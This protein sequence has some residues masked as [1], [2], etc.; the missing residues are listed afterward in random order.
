MRLKKSSPKTPSLIHIKLEYPE[1]KQSKKDM[2][3]SELNLLKIIEGITKYKKLRLEELEKKEKISKKFKDT[4]SNITKLQ[5]IFPKLKI[6]KILEKKAPITQEIEIK[7]PSRYVPQ[8]KS[9]IE[10]QL[11]QIQEKL[12]SLE[13]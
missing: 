11:S 7:A 8:K 9:D 5:K 3:H 2:L 12:K 1:A 10:D 6:P 4:K 13:R